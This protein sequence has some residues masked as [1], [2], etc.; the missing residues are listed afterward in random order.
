LFYGCEIKAMRSENNS[1][2]SIDT[3]IVS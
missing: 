2:L 3:S 1:E